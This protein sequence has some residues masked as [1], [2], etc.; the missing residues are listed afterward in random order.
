MIRF[1]TTRFGSVE[2]PEDK[3]ISFPEGILGFPGLKRYI[4]IDYEDTP[5]KWL[6]AVDDPDV[7]FIVM[8]AQSLSPDYSLQIDKQIK[9]LLKLEK[10][11]DLVVLFMSGSKEKGSLQI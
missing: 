11:E 7:A 4:L 3:M 8:P 9:D 10:E 1:E 6:Q 5:V 2:L